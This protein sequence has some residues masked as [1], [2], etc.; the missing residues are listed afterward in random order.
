MCAQLGA[1]VLPPDARLV[2][3]DA[4]AAEDVAVGGGER[5]AGVGDDAEVLD[6]DDRHPRQHCERRLQQQLAQKGIPNLDV[7]A[8]LRG[9]VAQRHRRERDAADRPDGAAPLVRRQS[10][11]SSVSWQLGTKVS[12]K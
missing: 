4:E 8:I 10:S 6:R 2:V 9:V 7:G 5:D 1:R 3:D 11:S 12:M